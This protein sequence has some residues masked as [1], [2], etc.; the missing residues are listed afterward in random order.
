MKTFAKNLLMSNF[1][2]INDLNKFAVTQVIPCVESVPLDQ[3]FT[4]AKSFLQQASICL[5]T[6]DKEREYMFLVQYVM[7]FKCI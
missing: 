2:S 7:Y 4:Q 3:Y 6:E 5:K 1:H